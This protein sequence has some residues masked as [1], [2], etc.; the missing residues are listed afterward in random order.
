MHRVSVFY[1]GNLLY[2]IC[3][4]KL[5]LPEFAYNKADW[6][7]LYFVPLSARYI[8]HVMNIDS[9]ERI[10]MFPFGTNYFRFVG[11]L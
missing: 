4:V 8:I 6:S 9:D 5:L 3:C 10:I 2:F 11:L 7:C 1:S